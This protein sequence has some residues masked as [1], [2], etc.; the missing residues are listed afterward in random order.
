MMNPEMVIIG[1]QDG[2]DTADVHK[3]KEFYAPLLQDN[4]RVVVGTWEEAECTK[5]FYNTFISMKLSFVNLIQDIGERIGNINVDLVTEALRDSAQRIIGPAYMTAGMGDGGP[6]HPRDN[7]ALRW[8]AMELHLGYDL[9]GA[10]IE[11]RECQARNIAKFLVEMAKAEGSNEVWLHGEAF[12][13]GLAYTQGSYSHLIAHFIVEQGMSAFFI[14]PHT[15]ASVTNVKGVILLAHN[16]EVEYDRGAQRSR[17]RFYCRFEPGSVIV[18]PW[19]RT[20]PED[21]PGCRLVLYGN[22]RLRR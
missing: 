12:K 7:I 20:K 11:S 1:T 21:V 15:G 9:F 18:D 6:C 16:S 10:I 22:T 13:P 4:P 2:T 14:D 8:L 5:I 3:L 17:P 19:R